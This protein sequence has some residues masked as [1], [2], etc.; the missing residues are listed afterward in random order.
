[1]ANRIHPTAVIGDGV[2]LGD[3]NDI[4]PFAVVV[5]PVVIGSGNWIGPHCVIGTPASD[6]GAPHPAAWD[7][8]PSG[9]PEQDG[10]GVRIGD[11]NVIREYCSVHQ[12]TQ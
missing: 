6:R 2:Q 3:G 12:G 4:G 8:A 5:G 10:F 1:M 7:G 9:D 11:R